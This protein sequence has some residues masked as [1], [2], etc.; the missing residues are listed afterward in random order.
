MVLPTKQRRANKPT[1]L[2]DRL[3]N[4]ISQAASALLSFTSWSSLV[5]SQRSHLEIP[6]TIKLLP[7]PAAPPL[8]QIASNGVPVL[9][10]SKPW[11]AAEK[12]SAIQCGSHQSTC[13]HND[14]LRTEMA[15]M[16][17]QHYW[18]VVPYHHV[19]HLPNLR[20]SPMGDVPQRDRRPR[21]IV[22][23]SFYNINRDT[24]PL[25]PS[26]A[27]KFNRVFE[28]ILHRI[29]HANR[30]YG[31]V[32]LMK[33]DLADGFD[34]VPLAPSNIPTQAVAFPNLPHEPTLVALPLVLPMGWVSSPPFF[35]ALTKTA[36][37][38]ANT[39][40][41]YHW[42]PP[43]HP[44]SHIANHPNNMQP[45]SRSNSMVSSSPHCLQPSP[46]PSLAQSIPGRSLPVS[47][48]APLLQPPSTR[49]SS[50]TSS[51]SPYLSALKF[52]TDELPTPVPPPSSLAPF[53]PHTPS[54]PLSYVDVHMDD[55]L[56][57]AQ[58]GPSNHL[59]FYR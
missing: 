9:L 28:R 21:P 46:F 52:A 25:A 1:T 32:H 45:V 12:D 26:E 18:T 35:C 6:S 57:L 38:S 19:Q 49:A 44:L 14:F 56:G 23:Y 59:S 39:R 53:L 33:V 55:F 37:D 2:T 5:T 58:G 34:R 31:L 4:L 10:N 13:Q 54:Q 7:H 17:K 11:S 30:A 3:G 16:V 41:R 20:L 15:D 50:T 47:T 27:M 40:L 51:G 42:S 29:H 48:A 8:S 22:D 36:A 24:I 43:P